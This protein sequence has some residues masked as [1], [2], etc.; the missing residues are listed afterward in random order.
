[1]VPQTSAKRSGS[2]V[3]LSM[4]V[5]FSALCFYNIRDSCLRDFWKVPKDTGSDKSI[6]THNEWAKIKIRIIRCPSGAI[7]I[8]YSGME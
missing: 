7:F 4:S 3:T 2:A 1:M 8:Y 6:N 5:S